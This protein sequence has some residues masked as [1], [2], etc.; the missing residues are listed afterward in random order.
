MVNHTDIIKELLPKYY[1]TYFTKYFQEKRYRIRLFFM[2]GLK[3]ENWKNRIK[4]EPCKLVLYSAYV[5]KLYNPNP[6]LAVIA[7][8]LSAHVRALTEV[9]YLELSKLCN[10]PNKS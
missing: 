9:I 6:C 2:N 5:K 3:P 8:F 10:A 4:W 7:Y 1:R